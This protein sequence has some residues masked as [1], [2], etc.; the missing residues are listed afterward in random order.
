MKIRYCKKYEKYV[1]TSPCEHL[2]E[3]KKCPFFDPSN[4]WQSL[5]ELEKD[6]NRPKWE[7]GKLLKPK[8]CAL[9]GREELHSRA[10]KR[11]KRT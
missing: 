4:F 1:S 5:A 3:G 9:L 10:N 2:N 11:K 6:Q 8:Q 7:I